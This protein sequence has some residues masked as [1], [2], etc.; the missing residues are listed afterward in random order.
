MNLAI[1]FA[2]AFAALSLGAPPAV[3]A[4][5]TRPITN[6]EAKAFAGYYQQQFAGTHPGKPVFSASRDDPKKPWTVGATLDS[7]PQRGLKALCRMQRSQFSYARRWSASGKPRW[8]AWIE[9]SG[10]KNV[11]LAVELLELLPDSEVLGLLENRF[12]LLH[13]ARIL[14]A[15]NSAC[16]SQRAYRFA[17]AQITVGSAGPSP[18]VM[19]GLVFKSDHGTLATVWARR[20]GADYSAWN[21]S[22]P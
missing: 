18:E 17:P 14:L 8:Y 3:A 12:A 6:A 9:R 21:V 16:A 1:S 11:H 20:S 4:P 10:C 15:G 5:E 22:C 19:A 2:F 7:Q 13:N